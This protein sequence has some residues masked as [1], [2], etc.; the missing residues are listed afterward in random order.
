MLLSV[1]GLDKL[2]VLTATETAVYCPACGAVIFTEQVS[3]T[4]TTTTAVATANSNKT[5]AV[6]NNQ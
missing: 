3:T 6:V 1:N 4:T 2:E 5:L